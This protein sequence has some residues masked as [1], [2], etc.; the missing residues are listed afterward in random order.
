ME[1]CEITSV[2][3]EIQKMP[4]LCKVWRSGRAIYMPLLYGI[5]MSSARMISFE[6]SNGGGFGNLDGMV[7]ACSRTS[8]M[9]AQGELWIV[10]RT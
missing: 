3:D 9:F 10:L 5:A 7:Q 4:D 8:Q 2:F 1:L 6:V